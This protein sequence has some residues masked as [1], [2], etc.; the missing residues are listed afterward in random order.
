[1][2]LATLVGM[3]V[4]F[5]L[6]AMAILMGGSIM[7]FINGPSVLIVIVG[8][9]AI[10]MVSYSIGEVIKAQ[11][12]MLKTVLFSLPDPIEEAKKMLEMAQKA[13]ANGILEI[14]GEIDN[15]DND[16][17]KN[18]L[19]MAVDGM[20]PDVIE[21][22]MKTDMAQMADRHASGVSIFK[23]SAEVA[24]SMGLIGTLIGLVQ[25]LG[26]LDDPS[27]IGPAM[28][29]ALLTTLYGAILAGMFFTP[30][31]AKLQKNSDDEVSLRT[32]YILSVLSIARQENP[33]QLEMLINTTLPPSA[34]ISVFE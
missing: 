27:A 8:T 32:V 33:R 3:V 12:I 4:G 6:L 9:F 16:F 24:P 17:L 29:V 19:A 10:T 23:K 18:G 7:A 30:L 34:R 25:M 5:G 20:S 26:N 13:R 31:A 2:D 15:I 22:V 11:S 28:A 21:R 1:M 14:Q